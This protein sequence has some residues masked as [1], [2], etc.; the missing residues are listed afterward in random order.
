MLAPLFDTFRPA[1][2]A[3]PAI[4]LAASYALPAAAT[5]LFVGNLARAYH[6]AT[7]APRGRR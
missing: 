4:A 6:R 1:I 5:A 3:A 2:D 7:T